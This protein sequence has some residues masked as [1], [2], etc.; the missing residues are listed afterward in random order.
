MTTIP[1]GWK[2]VRREVY[3]ALAAGVGH[4]ACL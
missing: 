1:E 3:D 2:L 4:V